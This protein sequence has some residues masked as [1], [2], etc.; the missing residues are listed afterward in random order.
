MVEAGGSLAGVTVE[1][2]EPVLERLGS[3][4][5]RPGGSDADVPRVQVGF[6]GG[7]EI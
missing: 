6:V 2:L 3:A 4:V 1:E 5:P 7:N